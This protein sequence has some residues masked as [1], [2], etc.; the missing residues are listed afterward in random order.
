VSPATN[1]SQ[2]DLYLTHFRRAVDALFK[3]AAAPG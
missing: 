3:G 1:E 2:V